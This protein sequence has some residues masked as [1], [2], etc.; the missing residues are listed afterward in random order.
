MLPSDAR[1]DPWSHLRP[2]HI[3]KRSEPEF[4]VSLARSSLAALERY[5]WDEGTAQE[6]FR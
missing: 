3:G 2:R 1:A 5:L 4:G 6:S